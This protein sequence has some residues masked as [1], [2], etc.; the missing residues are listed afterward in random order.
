MSIKKTPEHK[1]IV[2]NRVSIAFKSAVCAAVASMLLIPAAN[3]E[4][5]AP[6]ERNAGSVGTVTSSKS[7][8]K[9]SDTSR[10]S[11]LTHESVSVN[12]DDGASWE[13][14]G[15]SEIGENIIKDADRQTQEIE[16]KKKAAEEAKR[17][18]EEEASKKK[19]EEARS[20]AEAAS[21]SQPRVPLTIAN[22]ASSSPYG[23]G[24]ANG[25]LKNTGAAMWCTDLA[26]AALNSAGI[27]FGVHWPEEYVNVPGAVNIGTN[28]SDAEP[29]DLIIYARTGANGAHNDHIAVYIGNGMAVHGGWNY[30]PNVQIATANVGAVWAIIRVQ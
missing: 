13:L 1:R 6:A 7:F 8:P 28:L 18:V 24:I 29:G 14:G 5:L 27:S 21:R 23:A 4:V 3:A 12:L 19:A 11:L 25:A 9:W 2:N 15:E 26:T 22:N 20:L 16:A 17:K 10:K 30:A